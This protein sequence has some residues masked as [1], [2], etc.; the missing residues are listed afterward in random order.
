MSLGR[1]EVWATSPDPAIDAALKGLAAAL[2]ACRDPEALNGIEQRLTRMGSSASSHAS[3]LREQ[4][5]R[6]AAAAEARREERNA[7][8]REKRMREVL[9]TPL[10]DMISRRLNRRR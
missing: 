4:E 7:R 2:N 3:E 1:F 6:A 8:Q 5:R 9:D 10:S